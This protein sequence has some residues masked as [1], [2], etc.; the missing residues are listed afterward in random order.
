MPHATL[1]LWPMTTPGSPEKVKPDTW[2]G[3]AALRVRHW[4]LTWPQMPGIERARCGSLASSGLP[5]VVREPETPH[6]W[7]PMPSP[8]PRLDGTVLTDASAESMAALPSS[9]RMAVR[10]AGAGLAAWSLADAG[11][12]S[13]SERIGRLRSTG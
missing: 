2:K 7:E 12:Q 10:A 4:R 9:E 1:S 13:C 3:H 6:G 5:V 8:R 11:C